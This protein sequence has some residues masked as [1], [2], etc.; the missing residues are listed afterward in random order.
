MREP[1]ESSRTSQEAAA[2]FKQRLSKLGFD[3]LETR[4][5][6][7]EAMTSMLNF[8]K[9]ILDDLHSVNVSD[10]LNLAVLYHYR[11]GEWD[12]Y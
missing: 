11:E 9:G 10:E 8:G 6:S 1:A 12:L 2:S 5:L 4:F 3:G 7:S